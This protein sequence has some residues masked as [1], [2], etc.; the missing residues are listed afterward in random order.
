M[1]TALDDAGCPARRG[2]APDRRPGRG[3]RSTRRGRRSRRRRRPSCSGPRPYGRQVRAPTTGRSCSCSASCA[4]CSTSR[5][6]VLDNRSAAA[7]DDELLTV[8][9]GSVRAERGLRSRGGPPSDLAALEDRRAEH[10]VEAHPELDARPRRASTRPRSWRSCAARSPCASCRTPCWPWPRTSTSPAVPS[11][12]GLR[13]SVALPSP[14]IGWTGSAQ[15]LRVTLASQLRPDGVW[16]RSAL[17]VGVALGVAVAVAQAGDLPNSFWVGLGALTRAA[18]QRPRHRLHR[19]PGPRR[20]GGS[21]SRWRPA[22]CTWRRPAGCLWVLLP[23]TVVPRRL[24][25]DR[26]PLRRRS[27]VVHGARGG[28]VQPPRTGGVEGRSRPRAGRC[29]RPGGQPRREPGALASRRQ[30]RAR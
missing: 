3:G 8:C 18:E 29:D 19:A 27:G 14:A 2:D 1:A 11:S 7:G 20:H 30:P 28:A 22:W 25:P 26:G 9:A 6:L 5:R 4:G 12:T 16:L 24:H 21:A 13:P 10:L 23:V 17:R 15:R